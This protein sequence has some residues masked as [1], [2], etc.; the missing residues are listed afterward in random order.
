MKRRRTSG[1]RPSEKTIVEHLKEWEGDVADT[2]DAARYL[3]G[4]RTT[5][6]SRT[7]L[8]SLRSL[9]EKA[10]QDPAFAAPPPLPPT[11]EQRLQV[12]KKL[13]AFQVSTALSIWTSLPTALQRP[14]T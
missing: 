11:A 4:L 13:H 7:K 5:R 8:P 14:Q 1:A 2:D 9:V 12:G 10:Q 6:F 3:Q